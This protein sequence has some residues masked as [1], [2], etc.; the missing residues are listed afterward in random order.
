MNAHTMTAAAALLY[1]ISILST[2]HDISGKHYSNH[3]VNN[4]TGYRCTSTIDDSITN[5]E[6]HGICFVLYL[7]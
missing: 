7:S 1:E 4:F 5:L 2:A 3:T 6:T